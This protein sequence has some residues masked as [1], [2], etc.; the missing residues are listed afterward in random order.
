MR[1]TLARL[2]LS[3][4]PMQDQ[5]NVSFR[6]IERTEALLRSAQEWGMVI[7]DGLGSARSV[8]ASV[9]IDRRAPQ[10]GGSTTVRVDIVVDGQQIT[11]L[12]SSQDPHEALQGSFAAAAKRLRRIPAS[13]TGAS[14]VLRS[15]LQSPWQD[16]GLQGTDSSF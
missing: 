8:D 10:W 1:A 12:V 15:A 14:M 2:L 9:F 4:S 11:E 5:V 16:D 13:A 7:R 3:Y 6:G